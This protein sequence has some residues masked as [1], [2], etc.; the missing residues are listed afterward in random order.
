[1]RNIFIK[2]LTEKADKDTYLIVGDLGFGIVEP[3]VEKYLGQ[4]LN[5]G[6]AEQNMTGMA[7]GLALNGFK[8]FTYSIGNFNTT[9][10]LEQIRNDICYHD[11]DVTIASVGPGFM[12]GSQ[13]YSHH[14]VQDISLMGSLPNMKI[15]LP[16]DSAEVEFVMDYAFKEKGPKY[17]RLGRNCEKM[18]HKNQEQI[19]KI[20]SFNENNSE[21]ALIT[22]STTLETAF[23]AAE[24]L[25]K[26]GVNS[27]VFS[28]PIIDREFSENLRL[29]LSNYN[30]IFVIEE[31]INNL[32]F[33]A[34]I[35]NAFD[36]Q[37]KMIKSFGLE[38][39]SY[40]VVGNRDYLCGCHGINADN[41]AI[42]IQ[43]ILKEE[44][45]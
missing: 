33:A 34:L 36:G 45:I 32:G 12:Y 13:G 31:H 19:G 14:A 4:F 18:F 25:K 24:L 22:V 10:C 8:V 43:K 16:G 29:K 37:R 3:F 6:V 7:A 41:I 20:N 21:I 2:I 15:L 39:D 28:C 27:N 23:L 17:L 5:A 11:L 9:R 1:M 40:K 35:R 42:N 38:R 26:Q 44:K 30:Y